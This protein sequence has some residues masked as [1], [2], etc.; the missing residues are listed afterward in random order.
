MNTGIWIAD[1]E[2]R[3]ENGSIGAKRFSASSKHLAQYDADY[4]LS[5]VIR[6]AKEKAKNLVASHRIHTFFEETV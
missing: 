1:L 3:F 4:F 6:Y 2:I 5:E